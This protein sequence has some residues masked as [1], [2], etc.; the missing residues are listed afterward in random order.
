MA[1]YHRLGRID[2]QKA[3][4][5]YESEL[6]DRTG[7]AKPVNISVSMVP[8]TRKS[9]GSIIDLSDLKNAQ[10]GLQKQRAYFHQLFEKSPLA[11]VLNDANGKIIH[12][13]KGFENL[14][15]CK[16][17]SV[18]DKYNRNLVVPWDR[19]G[20]VVAFNKA[21]LNGQTVHKETMRK[22]RDGRLIPISVV[23]HPV[24]VN[25][26]TEGVFFIYEDISQRKA[27]ERELYQK[28]FYDSLT[29]IANRILFMERLNR[30]I[31][32]P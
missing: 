30:A 6:V 13:N 4:R 15:G 5:L 24:Q 31:E 14:F 26:N 21:I 12:V 16:M 11:I 2:R 17:D 8:G 28:A 27:F 3:P 23:G 19:F 9:L 18:R 25:G 32:R 22:H 1:E 10:Q 29:G 20:E 7:A